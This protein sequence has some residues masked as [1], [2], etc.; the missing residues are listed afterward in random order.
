MVGAGVVG[1]ARQGCRMVSAMMMAG[2][3]WASVVVGAGEPAADQGG[4]K[5]VFPGVR[6]ERGGEGKPGVVEFDGEVIADLSDPK[7]VLYL[8]VLACPRGSKEH[9]AL[10][11]T[12]VKPSQVHAAMLL[13]GFVPGKPVAWGADG[14]ASA[15]TGDAVTVEFVWKEG[16]EQKRAPA[17]DWVVNAKDWTRASALGKGFVFAGSVMVRRGDGTERYDGDSAGTLVGLA[18]FGSET[19]AWTR[20]F[21]PE[22][23]VDEPVWVAD[24]ARVPKVGTAVVVRIAREDAGK[25]AEQQSSK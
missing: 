8:E 10:V 6:V 14:K 5:E 4:I 9:E 3:V 22:A 21:S 19:V 12:K 23:S 11:M 24:R 2:A 1:A 7:K 17:L 13:A 20:V 16:E 25:A 18:G 15:P